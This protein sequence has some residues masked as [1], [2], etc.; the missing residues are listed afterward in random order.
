MYSVIIRII[1]INYVYCVV[2][3]LFVL[4]SYDSFGAAVT[5]VGFIVSESVNK[6]P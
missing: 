6:V 2:D 4:H 1:N 3:F 5:F